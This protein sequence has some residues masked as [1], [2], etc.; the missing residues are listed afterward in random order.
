M[1]RNTH[2]LILEDN[3]PDLVMLGFSIRE[4]GVSCDITPFSDGSEALRY[5]D[6]PSSRLADLMILD[7]NVP[8]ADGTVV[9]SQV[10]SN[11]RWA[12]VGVFMFTAFRDPV[13]IAR[14]EKLGANRCLNKP[15][16]L[17]GFARIGDAVRDWLAERAAPTEAGRE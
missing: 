8:G 6:D 15:M 16:D 14:V 11:P 5:V 10:R 2:V 4:A 3:E 13:E 1:N 17:A 7:F 9:L 12:E